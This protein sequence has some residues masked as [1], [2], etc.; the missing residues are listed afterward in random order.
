[1]LTAQELHRQILH[2]LVGVAVAVTF[3]FDI[4]SP[5]AVFLGIIVGGLLSILSKRI[6]VPIFDFLLN[7]IEREE[8]RKTFPGRGMIFFLVGVLLV[9]QLFPKDIALAA[10]MILACGDSVSHIVGERY[11][12]IQNLFN[13]RSKKLFEGTL[14]GTLAGFVGAIVFVPFSEALV[15]SFA[16]MIA[17]VIEIDLNGKPLDDNLIVPLVAGTAILLVRTYLYY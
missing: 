6:K 9:I 2:L 1:M 7:H 8:M 11:G 13:E 4:L 3:Y 14:A 5:L 15:G 10:I 12:Q 17:E 16:A